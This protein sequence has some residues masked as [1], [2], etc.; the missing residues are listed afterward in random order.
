M[1]MHH[2]YRAT[3]ILLLFAAE[4][5]AAATTAEP[6][7]QAHDSIAEAAVAA[8]HQSVST[9]SMRVVAVAEDLD[10]RL[11]LPQCSRALDADLPFTSGRSSRITV[12][13]RC[14]G[15]EAWKV[16][17]P[18]RLATYGQ[19]VVTTRAVSRD[20]VLTAQDLAV[21]ELELSGLQQGHLSEPAQVVG[22]K[23]RRS[24]AAGAPVTASML[25]T[26]PMIRRG[27]KVTVRATGSTLSIAT[28]G[29]ALADGGPG[30]IIEV[31]NESSGR[32]IQA[33]VRSEQVVEV[34]LN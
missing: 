17:I 15:A 21:T 1:N 24:V 30:D 18:V 34:L 12:E 16:Y 11:R 5:A 3:L 14:G 2:F 31:R 10:S 4:R 22:K 23:M 9:P 28:N 19:V 6:G 26:P 20:Q 29:E 25:L 27:Q 13:V 8:V 32:T 33:V 7:W